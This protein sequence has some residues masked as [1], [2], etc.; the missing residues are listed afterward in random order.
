MMLMKVMVVVMMM[1]ND[2]DDD[3]DDRGDGD[4][5]GDD[6]MGKG[7]NEAPYKFEPLSLSKFCFSLVQSPPGYPL[8]ISLKK[9]PIPSSHLTSH[10][11]KLL[12]LS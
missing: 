2:G 9:P 5:D 10:H 12:W 8:R 6:D 11:L 1:V 7:D 4:D 3:N